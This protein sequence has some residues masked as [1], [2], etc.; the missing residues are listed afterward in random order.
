MHRTGSIGD[1]IAESLSQEDAPRS[2]RMPRLPQPTPAM[3]ESAATDAEF[4]RL[5]DQIVELLE[6]IRATEERAFYAEQELQ[7]A[8]AQLMA[9]AARP[10]FTELAPEAPAPSRSV[11]PWIAVALVGGLA[12][13]GYFV[14][15]APLKARY[16]AEL[17]Q[18]E[19][20]SQQQAQALASMRDGFAKE[21]ETLEAEIA[22]AKS[23][24][25]AAVSGD[26]NAAP[27]AST[28]KTSAVSTMSA[29]SASAG[30]H[31][32]GNAE[33]RAARLEEKKAHHEEMLAKA[34]ERREAYAAKTA[35]RR[36]ALAAK[37]AEHKASA[38][39]K[40]SSDDDD[41]SSASHPKPEP[42]TAAAKPA[43]DE[44]SGTS[45]SDDPLDG[46]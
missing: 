21:R 28:S 27:V 4:E 41:D 17:T 39:K 20:Q 33:A 3:S 36:E 7:S 16:T 32:G 26:V 34:A 14:S 12:T 45:K 29:K 15:Y 11:L 46:L 9:A 5:G 1:D 37:R 44:L 19:A 13:A 40:G 43:S 42:K 23:A 24:P 31:A 35:E 22:A 38:G 10:H 18:A 6:R 30:A 25:P 2:Q 8:N